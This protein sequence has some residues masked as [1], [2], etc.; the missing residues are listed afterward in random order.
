M[1]IHLT[2]EEAAIHH[3]GGPE[4]ERILDEALARARHL[5]AR[6]GTSGPFF[7][8]GEVEVLHPDGRVLGVAVADP[9]APEQRELA[10]R[11]F[12]VADDQDV[13]SRDAATALVQAEYG[14]GQPRWCVTQHGTM[15]AERMGCW[16]AYASLVDERRPA[17]AEAEDED[18]EDDDA[19][20][21]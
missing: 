3:R 12:A 13:V 7:D 19:S 10:A 16:Q 17:P 8:Y 18:G 15:L 21:S 2:P 9:W 4:S 5:S 11:I 14:D 1:P 6:G 20:P